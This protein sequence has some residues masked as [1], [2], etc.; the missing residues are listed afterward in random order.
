MQ[1]A[2]QADELEEQN[3]RCAEQCAELEEEREVR[4]ELETRV[5]RAEEATQ[6]LQSEAELGRLR[7]IAEE[8]KKWEERESRWVQRLQELQKRTR[9]DPT[10]SHGGTSPVPTMDAAVDGAG[11]RYVAST[12]NGS[13]SRC[14]DG[15]MVSFSDSHSDNGGDAVPA[16]GY[17]PSVTD[18]QQINTSNGVTT[19]APG[20]PLSVLSTPALSANAPAFVPYSPTSGTTLTGSTVSVG[21]P[22]GL[23]ASQQ[24]TGGG[25]AMES[26]STL[27]A[28]PL[29]ALSVA[30]LAQQLP[31]LPNFN[32]ED[33]EGDGESFG[34][35]LERL[36]LV[37]ST[38]KWDDQAK[39]MNVATRLRGTAS[40]LYRSCTPQ[41]RSSYKELVAALRSRFTP[42]CIQSVQSS[43]FHE[44][45]Q[46][47]NETMP[48]TCVNCSTE[49]TQMPRVV[50][51]R[52]PWGSLSPVCCWPSRQ[53]QSKD[54]WTDW[55]I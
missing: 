34:D 17:R 14:E 52:K 12:H 33:L 15:R 19:T 35:W 37:A 5:E 39:L 32:G 24:S 26:V 49:P 13:G 9:D 25:E 2:Q 16:G 10:T 8:T 50:G 22:A 23:W 27:A 3:Q 20:G 46:C 28:A 21:A 48:R 42:V 29:D 41:Q 47:T 54:G 6:R 44:R 43:I 30:L 18:R 38:C 45:K 1:C 40:R 4:K 36:E 11:P 53:A 51:K 7:A 31:T 55:D